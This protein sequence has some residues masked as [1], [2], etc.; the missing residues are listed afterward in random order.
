VR[1]LIAAGLVALACAAAGGTALAA[2]TGD[3]RHFPDFSLMG[4]RVAVKKLPFT[5]RFFFG[6]EFGP[7]SS[8]SRQRGQAPVWFGEVERPHATIAAAGDGRWVCEAEEPDDAET[9]GGGSTCTSPAGARE[10]GLLHVSSCGKGPARHFR[11]SGLAPDGVTGI[12]LERTGGSIG[13]TVPVLENTFAFTVGREDITLRGVGDESAEA[14][15][16]PL[17]LAQTGDAGSNRGGCA[18]YTFAT[19]PPG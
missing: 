12:A 13:R 15:E 7:K 1:R 2:P 14:L 3:A 19:A 5:L 17:P 8:G 6:K 16:R 10:L 18:F 11:V 9:R 4:D